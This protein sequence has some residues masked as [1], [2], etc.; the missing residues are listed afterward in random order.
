MT[1]IWGWIWRKWPF[2]KKMFPPGALTKLVGGPLSQ[3]LPKI[4]EIALTGTAQERRM[5]LF[6]LEILYPLQ[7]EKKNVAE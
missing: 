5:A 1:N 3:N 6:Y 2:R 7:K 4:K